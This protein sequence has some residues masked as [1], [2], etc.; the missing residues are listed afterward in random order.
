V[1]ITTAGMER[2]REQIVEALVKA[3]SPRTIV[4]RNDAP[5]R[6]LEGLELY[7][8]R[9]LGEA[10]E[11]AAAL[12]EPQP[13][14][15]RGEEPDGSKPFY[16]M[17]V[18]T[19]WGDRLFVRYIRPYILASQRHADAPR[20]TPEAEE[21]MRRVDAMTLDATYNVF[22]DLMPGDI[23]FVNNYL[24][25][26][27]RTAYR[28]APDRRRHLV[29]LWLDD[30]ASARLGPGKMD[31]YLPELSRFT[32]GGGVARLEHGADGVGG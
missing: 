26:H 3:L 8:E 31:W 4:L 5:V 14:D 22:M 20:I 2:Q 24:V 29:R 15:F 1:Q 9:V 27:S 6:E 25:L 12:Y 18:F 13:Y 21:A 28:D 10:P 7:V 16:E 23:Q 30:V 17:P 32:R 19:Q 11:L